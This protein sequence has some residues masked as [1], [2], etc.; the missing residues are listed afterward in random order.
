[1]TNNILE[2]SSLNQKFSSGDNEIIVL[3]EVSLNIKQGEIVALV[4]QS[5]SGKT[6]LLQIAGLLSSPCSG[7]IKLLGQECSKMSD[8][9]KTTA[10]SQSIGF[11]Y[12]FHHLLPELSALENVSMPQLIAGVSKSKADDKSNQMLSE[13]GLADRKHHRPSELS[14]G[15]QQRV[16]IARSLANSPALLLADEPTGNLDKTNSDKIFSILYDSIKNYNSSAIIAT[17][18]H[19][20]AKK[21]DRIIMVENGMLSCS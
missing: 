10:R 21:M 2:I 19:E 16:A 12:Q 6:T 1:M 8:K 3:D 11:I 14:G 13:M 17:H 7:S 18:N 9:Q 4:G 15:E 20:L 5:G